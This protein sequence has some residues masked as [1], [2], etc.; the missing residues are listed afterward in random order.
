MILDTLSESRLIQLKELLVVL[1]DAID[2][3]PGARDLAQL[4]KQYRETLKEIDELE[5]SEPE[6]DEIATLLGGSDGVPGPIRKNIT[7][8]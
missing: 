8:I 1:A 3:K 7:E 6:H 5:G 4:A 2:N